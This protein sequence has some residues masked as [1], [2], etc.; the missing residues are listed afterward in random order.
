MIVSVSI[1]DLCPFSKFPHTGFPTHELLVF[2]FS[3]IICI[4]WHF[5]PISSFGLHERP[6]NFLFNIHAC[7]VLLF[8]LLM[9]Y[10]LPDNVPFDDKPQFL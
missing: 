5:H 6:S 10:F 7:G 1:P 9:P 3:F 2:V 8:F 4:I